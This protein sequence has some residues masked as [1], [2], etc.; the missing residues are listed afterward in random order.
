MCNRLWNTGTLMVTWSIIFLLLHTI[1]LPQINIDV[2]IL[3]FW[4]F[5]HLSDN[6]ANWGASF[7]KECCLPFFFRKF[8]KEKIFKYCFQNYY[9]AS[10]VSVFPRQRQICLL[11]GKATCLWN[12]FILGWILVFQVCIPSTDMIFVWTY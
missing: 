11:S 12:C 6:N 3:G 8:F 9:F 2:Y 1:A 10:C 5:I 4:I 7:A